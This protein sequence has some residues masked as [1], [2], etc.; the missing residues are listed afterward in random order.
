MKYSD[1]KAAVKEMLLEEGEI[2]GTDAYLDR[3]IRVALLESLAYFPSLRPDSLLTVTAPDVTVDGKACEFGI[4]AGITLTEVRIIPS[5]L[6]YD[7][8][9]TSAQTDGLGVIASPAGT[10]P[11][12]NDVVVFTD[13]AGTGWQVDSPYYVVG[14]DGTNWSVALTEGGSALP[15]TTV[16]PNDVEFR[17][18]NAEEYD[19]W[20]RLPVDRIPWTNRYNIINGLVA[21]CDKFY[22]ISPDR[23]RIIIHPI[24]DA[25]KILQ[26][27]HQTLGTKFDDA[28]NVNIP[29]AIE[30]QFINLC[31]DFVRSRIAK[32]IDRDAAL[33]AL[34]FKEFKRGLRSIFNEVPK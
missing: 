3:N 1:F 22:A 23:D 10:A 6:V 20:D 5:G 31:A 29:D 9:A 12:T 33:Y 32:D 17:K 2:H 27:S 15:E 13:S 26:V 16:S 18:M 30:D 11:A 34:N 8:E 24:I 28:D 4:P 7:G 14:S 19:T 21:G 25:E